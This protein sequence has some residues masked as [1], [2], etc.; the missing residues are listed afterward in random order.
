MQFHREKNKHRKKQ[1]ELVWK[2]IEKLKYLDQ[3][4]KKTSVVSS[5]SRSH[6]PI[7]NCSLFIW[8]E[9]YKPQATNYKYMLCSHSIQQS[10]HQYSFFSRSAKPAGGFKQ[11]H[12]KLR[13]SFWM[14]TEGIVFLHCS[15]FCKCTKN[16]LKDTVIS[17]TALK[18]SFCSHYL[19]VLLAVLPYK[20]LESWWV[21][22][23][24]HHEMF[25]ENVMPGRF[26]K[27]LQA[28]LIKQLFH[29]HL[30]DMRWL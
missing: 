19:R 23:S 7:D 30:L 9:E 29:S 2:F 24:V 26:T 21:I 15:Y 8:H 1:Q 10:G 5:W 22:K 11:V 4:R 14:A 28:F 12:N 6:S 13:M 20:I 17:T 16:P 18:N 25:C 3:L 27:I